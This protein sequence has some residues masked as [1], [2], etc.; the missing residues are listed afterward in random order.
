LVELGGLVVPFLT[1][2]GSIFVAELTD[3]DAILLLTLATKTNPWRVFAAGSIAFTITSAI[4]VLLGSALVLFIPIFWIKI[5]GGVIMLGYAF[6]QYLRGLK[7]EK[8]IESRGDGLA[9]ESARG[10]W[11]AFFAILLALIV[12]DLA[13][14]ATELLTVIFV[15][16]YEDLLLVF[17]AA[18]VALTAASGVEAVLGNRL[19]R[20]L[21]A[22]RIRYL[23]I[24]VFL[25]IGSVIL[26][27]AVF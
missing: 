14:D 27:T 17:L 23:S 3:K 2:A 21:S 10:A 9:K 13:G 26:L 7:E 4:I 25:I 20:L 22:K 8:D 12:L 5:A 1:I 24:I 6:F 15:A 11:R 16:Q 19:G 18:A